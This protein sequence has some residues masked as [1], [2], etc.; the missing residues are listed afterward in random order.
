MSC[1]VQGRPGGNIKYVQISLAHTEI[2]NIVI[3]IECHGVEITGP[4]L[5]V[6][7]KT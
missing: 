4:I 1:V 5:P 6:C 3:K 7:Y 2:L